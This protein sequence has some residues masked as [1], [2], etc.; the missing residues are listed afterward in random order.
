MNLYLAQ[1]LVVGNVSFTSF[2]LKALVLLVL[3]CLLA[4]FSTSSLTVYS[5]H[6][7]TS[8]PVGE[9]TA[10]QPHQSGLGAFKWMALPWSKTLITIS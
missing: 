2:L 5:I 10:R 3:L 9:R 4:L 6:C 8:N 1:P 7:V